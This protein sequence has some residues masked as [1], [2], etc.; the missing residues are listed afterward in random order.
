MQAFGQKLQITRPPQVSQLA[1]EKH[2]DELVD[3]YQRVHNLKCVL[4]SDHRS[5]SSSI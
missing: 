3:I 4:S 5:A 1:F 2:F